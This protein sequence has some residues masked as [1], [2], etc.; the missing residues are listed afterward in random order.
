MQTMLK[1]VKPTS[2]ASEVMQQMMDMIKSGRWKPGDRIPNEMELMELTG[3]S[4]ST[5]R[6]AKRSLLSMN[7]IESKTGSGS[8]VRP[9]TVASVMDNQMLEMILSDEEEMLNEARMLLEM[10]IAILAAQRANEEDF[11]RL[12]ESLEDLRQAVLHNGDVF[13]SGRRFHH[14]LSQ[15]SR[16]N[17]MVKINEILTMMLEKLQAPTYNETYNKQMEVKVHA[18]IVEAIKARNVART[19]QAVNDHFSYVRSLSKS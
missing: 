9:F 7:L 12:D 19:M 10:Q 16:N 6:E 5:I 3:V 1:T 2:A 14:A 8:F 15:A 4:R 11:R 18:D 17:V 13:R